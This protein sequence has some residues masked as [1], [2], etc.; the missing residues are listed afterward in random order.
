[1]GF[2]GNMAKAEVLPHFEG[3]FGAGIL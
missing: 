3:A 2:Y 1:L